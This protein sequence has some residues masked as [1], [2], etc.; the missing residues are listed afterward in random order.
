MGS[1]QSQPKQVATWAAPSKFIGAELPKFLKAHIPSHVHPRYW[2]WNYTILCLPWWISFLLCQVSPF[3]F[4]FSFFG[5]RNVYPVQPLLEVCNLFCFVFCFYRGSQLRVYLESGRRLDLDFW[6]RLELLRLWGLLEMDWIHI[7][8]WDGHK[9]LGARGRVLQC[10]SGMS[11]KCY[12]LK[13]WSPACDTIGRWV[14]V[15]RI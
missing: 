14:L 13:A 11:L 2:T 12:V 7:A 8:F 6:A 10:G 3:C 9:P 4:P 15:E 5:N 1:R